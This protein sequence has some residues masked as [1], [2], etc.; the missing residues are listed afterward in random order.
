[1]KEIKSKPLQAGISSS[2]SST[3]KGR[4]VSDVAIAEQFC[5]VASDMRSILQS[6][7]NSNDIQK[8]TVET[9]QDNSSKL[10]KLDSVVD[11]LDIMIG[12][13]VD[14]NENVKK[15][16]ETVKA[17]VCENQKHVDTMQIFLQLLEQHI[18]QLDE[19]ST[20]MARS[21]LDDGAFTA[22]VNKVKEEKQSKK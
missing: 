20:I 4:S 11:K 3:N 15:S 22:L 14:L 6:L 18:S 16:D 17:A 9:I 12:H 19:S 8:T 13:L 5:I 2:I 1:M 7:R 10:S 21:L